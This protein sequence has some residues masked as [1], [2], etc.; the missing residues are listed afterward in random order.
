MVQ[1]M[2]ELEAVRRMKHG[3]I[4]GLEAIVRR[5]QVP[6]LRAVY[7]ITRDLP[8]AEDVVQEG[9]L[10][11]YERIGQFDVSRPFGPWFLRS[12]VNA[13]IKVA[14]RAERTVPLHADRAGRVPRWAIGD[15]SGDPVTALERAETRLAIVDALAAL[16]PGQR[17]VVVCRY[18]LDLSEADTARNLAVPPGTVKRRLHDARARLRAMLNRGHGGPVSH[19]SRQED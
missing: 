18:Y 16:S 8:L 3:D 5:Y 1:D 9:F 13:A 10:R 15:R 11:A 4:S 7:L 19:S 2:D 12:V 14:V 17:A 6:A